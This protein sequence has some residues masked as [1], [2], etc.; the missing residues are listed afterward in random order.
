MTAGDL[1]VGLSVGVW[2]PAPSAMTAGDLTVG[3]SVAVWR[4]APSAMTAG[5]LTVGLSVAVWR[6]A[7]SASGAIFEVRR[8]NAA[9]I[10]LESGSKLPALQ[11]GRIRRPGASTVSAASAQHQN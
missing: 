10:G 1:T 8:L 2:R 5:D 11:S 6:P 7:P 3:L 4:P 9:F